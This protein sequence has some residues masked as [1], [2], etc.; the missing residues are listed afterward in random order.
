MLLQLILVIVRFSSK[1]EGAVA[2]TFMA[3][4]AVLRIVG[5]QF[6]QPDADIGFWFGSITQ[7]QLLS[8][9]M[10]LVTAF[11]AYLQF[12]ARP[13]PQSELPS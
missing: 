9:I 6:R 8:A 13:V 3:S 1:R 7:G 2:L 5:E 12:F 11:L 4:Y 10:L